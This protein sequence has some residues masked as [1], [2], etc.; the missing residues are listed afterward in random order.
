MHRP[1]TPFSWIERLSAAASNQPVRRGRNV[2]HQGHEARR[3]GERF[4]QRLPEIHVLAFIQ[5]REDEVVELEQ[6][7]ELALEALRVEKVLQ[8]DRAA[9]DLVLVGRADAAAG[10]ADLLLAFRRLAR[11]V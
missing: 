10:G 1:E 4:L 7:L 6:F 8:P 11:A 3:E 2:R 9:R 5:M